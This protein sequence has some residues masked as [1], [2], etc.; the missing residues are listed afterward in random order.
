L[1]IALCAITGSA[2]VRAGG[3]YDLALVL[4]VDCSGSVDPGEYRL[5]MDGIA[6]AFRDPEVIAAATSGPHGAITVDLM[7]WSDPDEQKFDSGWYVIDSPQAAEIFAHRVEHYDRL[8]G[9]GTGIGLAVGYGVTLIETSGLL[10]SRKVIDVSG[11]GVESFE[12]REPHFKLPEAQAMRSKA[13]IIVNGLAIETDYPELGRY[14]RDNVIGGP[15]SF[16]MDVAN[17]RDYARAIRQK[18][19]REIRPLLSSLPN[20]HLVRKL[21]E[22]YS[23]EE[24]NNQR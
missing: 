14:Y 17:Y 19:L 18:L 16:E 6:A 24:Q 8:G 12:L 3:N 9:G 15:G 23:G 13:G 21:A 5:Q 20:P 11:D 22:V 4:A 1:A 7:T 10:V 2:V